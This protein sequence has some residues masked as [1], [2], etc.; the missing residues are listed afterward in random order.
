MRFCETTIAGV[1]LV[2]IEPNHDQRGYFARTYSRQEFRA[3]GLMDDIEQ[4][5]VSFNR[6]RGTVRGMHFQAAPHA[7]AKLVACIQGRMFDVA[8]DVRRDSGTFG[9]WFGIELSPDNLRMLYLP[10]GIA[11][12]FQTLEDSSAVSYQI[13]EAFHPESSR[14]IRWN[15]PRVAIRWPLSE[16]LTISERDRTWPDWPSAG[17]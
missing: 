6:R 17:E 8:L 11:H 7:E 5:S 16:N 3:N 4:S 13:S 15:D 9:Q 2:E 10:A 1:I 12:G 14:G